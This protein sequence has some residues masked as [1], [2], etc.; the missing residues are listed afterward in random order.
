MP[1]LKPLRPADEKHL[2]AYTR[3]R[4]RNVKVGEDILVELKWCAVTKVQERT[5][6]VEVSGSLGKRIRRDEKFITFGC[7]TS[8]AHLA[9]SVLS[10][11]WINTRKRKE[12]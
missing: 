8:M 10:D 6:N 4:A 9:Y 2:W 12:Q 11:G 7:D 5:T 3:K 1:K